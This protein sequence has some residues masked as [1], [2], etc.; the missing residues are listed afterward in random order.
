M[1]VITQQVLRLSP[2]TSDNV[3][4]LQNFL[5]AHQKK[6]NVLTNDT[7]NSLKNSHFLVSISKIKSEPKV[8][9]NE[10]TNENKTPGTALTYSEIGVVLSVYLNVICSSR[11]L[12]SPESISVVCHLPKVEQCL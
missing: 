3:V 12:G 9:R 1:R 4:L 8:T 7:K 10:L 11:Y 5:N 6:I 2:Q